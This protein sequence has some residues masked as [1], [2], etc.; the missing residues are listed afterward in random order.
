MS[1]K[2]NIGAHGAGP[3]PVP[4]ANDDKRAAMSAARDQKKNT[5]AAVGAAKN[6]KTPRADQSAAED[7]KI[8]GASQSAATTAYQENISYSEAFP[9]SSEAFPELFQQSDF[10]SVFHILKSIKSG[11]DEIDLHIEELIENIAG[12]SNH[13][14]L[15]TQ[16]RA[17]RKK[18]EQ[19]LTN[20]TIKLTIIHGVGKGRLKE[21][22]LQLLKDYEGI[23][24]E[25]APV[26]R[27]GRGALSVLLV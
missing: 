1:K 16:L 27:Y 25:P 18:I 26:A 9:R 14:M 17:C 19:C 6:K 21:E 20:G 22:V 5:R 13:D 15:Q 2:P 4:P 10:I 7:N 11:Q 12:M 8:S 24:W 3:G 23:K